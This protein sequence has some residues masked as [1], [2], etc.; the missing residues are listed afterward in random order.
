MTVL[1]RHEHAGAQVLRLN[2]PEKRNAL[3]LELWERLREALTALRTEH[4]RC[5]VINGA[6][7]GFCG[8]GDWIEAS[9]ADDTYLERVYAIT[10]EVVL[11]LYEMPCPTIAM[12]HGATVGAGLELALACD[13]RFASS[14]A[15][16]QVGFTKFA[17]PPEAISAAMLPRLLGIDRAKHFVFSGEKWSA[18]QAQR[19]G[20]VSDV[21]ADESFR[22]ETMSYA[23]MLAKG[24][25]LAYSMGKA[26]MNDS[27][28]CSVH[29]TIKTAYQ[30]GVKSQASNDAAEGLAAM[31][32]RREPVFSGN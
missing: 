12:T 27:F 29:D 11:A 30:H 17:A 21:F 3:N 18:A 20:L 19:Y 31:L 5:V 25:T 26:M 1:E 2:R 16:F 13:F 23:E 6:G 22:D 8:G 15:S 24:P 14:G 4:A 9:T 28:V 10:H 7:V 32:E